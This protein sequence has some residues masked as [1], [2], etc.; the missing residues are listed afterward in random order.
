MTKH[1][2]VENADT[3]KYKIK[4]L[5]QEKAFNAEGFEWKTVETIELNHPTAMREITIWPARRF[6]VEE[7]GEN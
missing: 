1:V 5:V 4:V 6:I 2:R 3:S 7:N